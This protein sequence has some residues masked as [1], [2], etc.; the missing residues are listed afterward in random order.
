MVKQLKNNWYSAL[1]VLL[2][3]GIILVLGFY[4]TSQEEKNFFYAPTASD[5]QTW[6]FEEQFRSSSHIFY[7]LGRL[8]TE[9]SCWV[10]AS[11]LDG[12]EKQ[13]L[14]IQLDA[15]SNETGLLL[16]PDK[17]NVLV[18]REKKAILIKTDTLA[19]KE[20]LR[21][22]NETEFGTYTSFPSFVPVGRWVD[23]NTIEL[24]VFASGAIEGY[25]YLDS[26][27]KTVVVP[28]PVP[29][30]KKLIKIN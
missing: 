7:C 15:G 5:E 22:E 1:G 14:K 9:S 16:S 2:A 12:N 18:V 11:R 3:L 24:G 19:Q 8:A 23:S 6:D 4:F 10:Y 27:G 28:D 13:W 25:S 29:V 26:E 30:E 17:K 21:A 20:L